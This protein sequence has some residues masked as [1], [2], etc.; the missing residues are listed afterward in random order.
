[1]ATTRNRAPA[2]SRPA[3]LS[4]ERI[5]EAALAL[6]EADGLA[7][8]STRR[9]GDRLGCKAMSIYHHFESK[10]LLL[11]ALVEHAIAT[12][13]VPPPGPDALDR[14][15]AT[16]YAYRAMTRRFA[17]LFPLISVH[18]HNT[19]R[20]VRFLE[21]ILRLIRA[22]EPDVERSAR[23]FRI[24]GYYLVGAALDETAGYARGPSAV[25][26]ADAD[27]IARECPTLAASAPYFQSRHWDATFDLGIELL[28]AGI[29]QA[30]GRSG[31]TSNS[32]RA[33][34]TAGRTG[35]ASKAPPAAATNRRRRVR[36]RS[37]R[38]L[39]RATRA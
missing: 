21:S 16:L 12:V 27:F 18:R 26:P 22:V 5:V 24:L 20:G 8:F 39:P 31:P 29:S 4:R 32:K 2:E 33:A 1:M 3:A 10:Q 25:E 14:L 7:A 17:A 9:L 15:R 23:H 11:D 34:G 38:S 30:A 19:E 6:V 28:L 37:A 35:R 36:G 13:D